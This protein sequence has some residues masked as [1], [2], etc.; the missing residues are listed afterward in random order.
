MSSGLKLIAWQLKDVAAAQQLQIDL[1]K[2]IL[3]SGP[4]GSGK[5]SIMYLLNTLPS[6]SRFNIRRC[7]EIQRELI[8]E[9]AGI[10]PH[11]S[12]Q[13][14][15]NSSRQSIVYCFDGLGKELKQLP[16]PHSP[17]A[18]EDILL[19]RYLLH[20][21]HGLVTHLTTSLSPLQIKTHYGLQVSSRLP[22]LFNLVFLD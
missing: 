1:G 12:T 11:Y 13:C 21:S 18:M 5:T 7:K 19:E 9:G 22:Q 3:L 20:Q 10:L 2:G 16:Y 14:L 8:K 6:G 4:A 17:K 15:G